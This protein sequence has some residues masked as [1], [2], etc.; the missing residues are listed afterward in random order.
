MVSGHVF[1]HEV[2]MIPLNESQTS[3]SCDCSGAVPEPEPAASCGCG[4]VE[5]VKVYEESRPAC[6]CGSTTPAQGNSQAAPRKSKVTLSMLLNELFRSGKYLLIMFTGFAFV[7]FFLNGLIPASWVEILFGSGHIYNVPLA[8][9]LG[10]PL[11]INSEAS[12]PLIRALLDNGMS[13]G[14]ALAFLISGAGTSIGAIAGA[15]T[16]ARWRVVGLVVGV[17]WLG[18]IL[19]GFAFDLMIK[20]L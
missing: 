11:Y 17:L 8:A 4:Q 13:Q 10:L 15:L 14:A 9:T 5:A 7:G 16:I 2:P 6:G 18:A 3:S 1:K 19:S 12:L 20:I